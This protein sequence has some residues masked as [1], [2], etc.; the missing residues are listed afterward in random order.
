VLKV[1]PNASSHKGK[2]VEDTKSL[3]GGERSFSTLAFILALG[4][5][6]SA[7][8]RVIDEFDVYMD[9]V[10][11]ALSMKLLAKAAQDRKD[12]QFIFITPQ[13]ITSLAI[14]DSCRLKKLKPV[15]RHQRTLTEMGMGAS[16]DS[17]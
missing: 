5:S 16:P 13:D 4:E 7:P 15:D 8:F 6:S 12:M 2:A 14:S 9:S 10:N 17:N 3:S 11:R 1:N